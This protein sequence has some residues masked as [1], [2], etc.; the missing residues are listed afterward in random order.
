MKTFIHLILILNLFLTAECI[1]QNRSIAFSDKPFSEIQTMAKNENKLIFIDAYASWCGPCKWMSANI[2]TN[3]TVADFY[4]KNFICAKYDMEKGEGVRLSRQYEVMAYPTLL[5]INSAGELVHLKVGA[6]KSIPE[7]IELGITA[8]DPNECYAAYLKRYSKGENTPSF[9]YHY[10][11]LLSD[12]YRP[13]DVPLNKYLSAQK[14]ADLVSNTN[15]KILFSF[16]NNMDSREFRYLLAH[17]Q[18]FTSMHGK[19]SV[20]A[21]LYNVYFKA[22]LDLGRSD[23]MPDSSYSLLKRRISNSG[24]SGAG[25]V[26]FDADLYLCQMQGDVQKLIDIAYRDLDKYYH[27]DPVMLSELASL[28]HDYSKDKEY[29]E[30]ASLWLKRSVELKPGIE[31]NQTC[32]ALLYDLGRKEEAIKYCKDALIIAR[33]QNVSSEPIEQDLKKYES[34]Q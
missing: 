22:L 12:A 4:N 11:K 32:A 29:L 16:C 3:D 28:V 2:F 25:K 30:K 8:M 6:A 10:L 27:D 23:K 19:D 17:Q 13:V 31:N 18:E 14:E 34:G 15:W 20:N 21:K 1:G 7:Y 24:Y 33:K 26:I 5:F 9:M